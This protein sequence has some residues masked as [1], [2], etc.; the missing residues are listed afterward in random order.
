MSR[1]WRAARASAATPVRAWGE[2]LVAPAAEFPE[3]AASS[4][5]ALLSAVDLSDCCGLTGVVVVVAFSLS[6]FVFFSFL[7]P[8]PSLASS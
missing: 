2:A 3:Q 8:T 4:Q 5:V 6:C 1:N 7:L